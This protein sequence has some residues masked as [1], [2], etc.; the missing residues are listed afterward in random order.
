MLK[1]TK[2]LWLLF[3]IGLFFVPYM[4][5]S[6]YHQH[7]LIVSGIYVLLA[8]GLNLIIGYTGQVSLGHAAFYGLGA[9]TAAILS[10]RFGSPFWLN[11]FAAPVV[12]GIFGILLGLP[13][14]RLA[15]HYLGIASL[16]F[17]IIIEQIFLNWISL[18]RG[19][20]GITGISPPRIS[21]LNFQFTRKSHYYYLILVITLVVFFLFR[22]LVSY[23]TGR[24]FAAIRENEISAKAMGIHTT[25]YKVLAFT[26]A[27][28][29]AGVAGCFFAHY[30]LF[31]SPDSFAFLE[32]I[33]I[34]ALT[35]IGG[36]GNILGSFV[37]GLFLTILPEYL[38][39][40]NEAREVIYGAMLLLIIMFMP[41]GLSGFIFGLRRRYMSRKR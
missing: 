30:L 17:G 2:I 37:G 24:A 13:T 15:G 36:T 3:V 7:L 26:I 35:I 40:L 8:L 31:V 9:Y 1:G 11:L 28:M 5:R 14:I 27:A 21:F 39:A 19:P 23:R 6:E 38:R 32:S 25:Y 16:T 34:L 4:V 18:T 10:V 33:N 22:R 41:K 29:I 20:M 12:A